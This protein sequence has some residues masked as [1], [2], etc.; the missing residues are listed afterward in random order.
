LLRSDSRIFKS[1]APVIK[2]HCA[3]HL[4]LFYHGGN[5]QFYGGIGYIFTIIN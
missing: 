3:V 5:T 2:R 4:Y 1:V